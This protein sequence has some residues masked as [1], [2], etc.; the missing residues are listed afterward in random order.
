MNFDGKAFVKNTTTRTFISTHGYSNVRDIRSN[1]INNFSLTLDSDTAYVQPM[2]LTNMEIL[3]P[4]DIIYTS[5]LIPYTVQVI[6][7]QNSQLL[8]PQTF[9]LTKDNKIHD[10]QDDFEYY[11]KQI[12]IFRLQPTN[13]K[14]NPKSAIVTN[15]VLEESITTFSAIT[16]NVNSKLEVVIP[17]KGTNYSDISIVVQKNSFIE[18]KISDSVTDVVNLPDDLMY[19]PGYIKGTFT[20]SGEYNIKIKYPD[21]EQILNIIVPYYQRLS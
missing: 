15:S 16:V 18:L 12:Y 5:G 1:D 17:E 8:C 19:L 4:I 6:S 13:I 21:G 11:A 3:K 2:Y 20:K 7:E 9:I 10:I 14:Y